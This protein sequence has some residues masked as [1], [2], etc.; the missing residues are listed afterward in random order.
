MPA[1]HPAKPAGTVVGQELQFPACPAPSRPAPE[2]TGEGSG[3][4]WR[5]GALGHVVQRR[6][7]PRAVSRQF[8]KSRGGRGGSREISA[9]RPAPRTAGERARWVLRAGG[10]VSGTERNRTS[11]GARACA[12]AEEA[13]AERGTPSCAGTCVERG[14]AVGPAAGGGRFNRCGR[15]HRPHRHV[16]GEKKR[17]GAGGQEG[18]APGGGDPRPPSFAR[19][20]RYRVLRRRLGRHRRRWR[21]GGPRRARP[22][23]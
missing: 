4:G 5:R 23:M 15:C 10:R 19:S 1:L 3:R 22:L 14:R 12:A 9:L 18:A 20:S 7:P 13:S 11:R 21:S 6:P 2:V 8:E 16:R 17:A